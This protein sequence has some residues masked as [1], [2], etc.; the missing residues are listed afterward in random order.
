MHLRFFVARRRPCT[1]GENDRARGLQA[2]AH[3]CGKLA[4]ITLAFMR[5]SHPLVCDLQVIGSRGTIVVHTWR[6]VVQQ[7]KT[8][9]SQSVSAISKFTY[10]VE[11]G[12]FESAT[13]LPARQMM[14]GFR[15]PHETSLSS[16][17][18]R[19]FSA[20][21]LICPVFAAGCYTGCYGKSARFRDQK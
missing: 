11:H 18:Q 3:N 20:D 16:K 5:E 12:G 7:P 14:C 8:W 15:A 17:S 21:C 9:Q 10:P 2:R 13:P 19:S 4:E 1:I 6:I